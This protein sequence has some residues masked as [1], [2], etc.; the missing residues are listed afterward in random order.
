MTLEPMPAERSRI[1]VTTTRRH[2]GVRRADWRDD[3]GSTSFLAAG[4]RG[5]CDVVPCKK[6]VEGERLRPVAF[7]GDDSF[8]ASV[9]RPFAQR[10]A[11]VSLVAQ[12]FFRRFVSADQTFRNRTIV[13][14]PAGQKDGKKTAFSICNFVYLRIA[15]A[16][17]ASN[18]LFLLP[19]FRPMPQRR[20]LIICVL[21][22]RGPQALETVFPQPAPRPSHKAVVNRRR[23]AVFRRTIAPTAAAFQ[24]MQNA[25]DHPAII[26]AIFTAYVRGQERHDLFGTRRRSAKTSCF[27]SAVLFSSR[28]NHYPLQLSGDLLSSDPNCCLSPAH[29]LS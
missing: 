24:H 9:F 17:R 12:K 29:Q 10:L 21:I 26:H 27:S 25:A 22:F 23:R 8:R 4:T 15:P 5:R 2:K 1:S 6:F 16:A 11:V 20:V 28:E 7:V 18:R 19:P 3:R 13:C 14:L